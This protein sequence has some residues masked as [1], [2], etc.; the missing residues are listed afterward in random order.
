MKS[1][2]TKFTISGIEYTGPTIHAESRED[3]E[4][5]AADMDVCVTLVVEGEWE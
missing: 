1:F 2:I 4:K 5:Q 3:A